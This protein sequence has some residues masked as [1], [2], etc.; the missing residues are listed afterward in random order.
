[1]SKNKA[2]EEYVKR[3]A[4]NYCKGN[5]EEAKKHALVKSVKEHYDEE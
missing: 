3:Y 2:F 1:M 4:D 5:I